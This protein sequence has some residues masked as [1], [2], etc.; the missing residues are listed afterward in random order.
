MQARSKR[1]TDGRT[2]VLEADTR[3]GGLANRNGR[4]S[5]LKDARAESQSDIG[6]K[7]DAERR[8]KN[9]DGRR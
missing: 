9:R 5:E 6:G 7:R 4:Q 8:I 2:G 3:Y 1:Q